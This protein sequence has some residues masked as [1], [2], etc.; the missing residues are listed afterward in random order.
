[1]LVRGNDATLP[2]LR[3]RIPQIV[4]KLKSQGSLFKVGYMHQSTL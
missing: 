3:K 1:M 2:V 4:N